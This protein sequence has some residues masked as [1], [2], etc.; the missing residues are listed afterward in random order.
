MTDN[1]FAWTELAVEICDGEDIDCD[2][3]VDED[4]SQNSILWYE[5]SD[6]DN[7]GNPDSSVGSCAA[8]DGYVLNSEDCDDNEITISPVG[9]EFCDNTDNNCDGVIDEDAVDS[10]PFYEDG[11]EDG[12]GEILEEDM[13]PTLHAVHLMVLSNLRET[14]TTTMI[15]Y[16]RI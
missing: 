15:P 9:I 6:G 7:F 5:D 2:A 10:V 16:I 11:D 13:E 1:A 12:F 8:P 14:A 3:D 4:D